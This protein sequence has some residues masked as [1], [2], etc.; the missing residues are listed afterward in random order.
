MGYHKKLIEHQNKPENQLPESII[1][2]TMNI[3]IQMY[4]NCFIS[5]NTLV[6]NTKMPIEPLGLSECL[7][8]VVGLTLISS[9]DIEKKI[10]IFS[11]D[12]GD[13]NKLQPIFHDFMEFLNQFF[14]NEMSYFSSLGYSGASE[15]ANYLKNQLSIQHVYDPMAG[16]GFI[17]R[18]LQEQKLDIF[19]GDINP[20]FKICDITKM[21]ATEWIH[22][23][24]IN[25]NSVLII[26]APPPSFMHSDG[27]THK[28]ENL[29]DSILLQWFI[30]IRSSNAQ[31]A[32]YILIWGE[33]PDYSIYVPQHIV[34]SLKL[35]IEDLKLVL[36][37]TDRELGMF[38]ATFILV[39]PENPHSTSEKAR[40][41][42]NELYSEIA[43]F[44]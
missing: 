44:K 15:L 42:A 36:P 14:S 24:T 27:E 2:R 41:L 35:V 23:L 43:G 16:N 38:S 10:Y 34:E 22:Q 4:I 7:D 20:K 12:Y 25:D 32:G 18:M 19:G 33:D 5:I 8:R 39:R 31:N 3:L 17:I 40:K 30:A 6:Q 29:I 28:I 9:F 26:A 13:L 1:R 37:N 11:G 21:G